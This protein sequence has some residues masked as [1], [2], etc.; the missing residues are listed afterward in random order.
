VAAWGC[1]PVEDALLELEVC[2]EARVEV[3]GGLLTAIEELL[4]AVSRW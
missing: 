1:D 2:A 4:P 3:V